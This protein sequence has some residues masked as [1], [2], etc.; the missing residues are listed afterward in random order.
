LR[1]LPFVAVNRNRSTFRLIFFGAA[2]NITVPGTGSVNDNPMSP[3]SRIV[4]PAL[5]RIKYAVALR[6]IGQDFDRRN[7][8]SFDIRCGGNEYFAQCG[9]QDPPSEMPVSINYTSKDLQDLDEAGME[10]RGKVST[11]TDFLNQIQILRTLGGYIDKIEGR[12]IRITNNE[13][14]GADSGLKIEYFNAEGERVLEA[15]TS[16][17]V[18]DLCVAMY[19]QRGRLTGTGGGIP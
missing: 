7:L 13:R 3:L 8:K 12:L 14:L 5:S 9:Y 18:Y 15:R 4:N 16:V 2:R 19:K 10:H 17:A 11:S 6:A 1:T